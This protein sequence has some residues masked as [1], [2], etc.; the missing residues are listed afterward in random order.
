MTWV[1]RFLT[2]R[3]IALKIQNFISPFF[4]FPHFLSN[5]TEDQLKPNEQK[6]EL[7]LDTY[8]RKNKLKSQKKNKSRE[9][10]LAFSSIF[11][12]NKIK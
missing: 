10:K 9:H 11:D 8:R 4:L 7:N 3:K 12:K 2:P 5:Q 6:Q 1:L